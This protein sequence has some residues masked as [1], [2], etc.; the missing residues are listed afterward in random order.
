MGGALALG[1]LGAS[2]DL[3]CGVPF[4]GVNFDLFD[5][6]KLAAEKKAVQVQ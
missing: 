5:A 6:A 1:G 2:Q 4:Y 3:S